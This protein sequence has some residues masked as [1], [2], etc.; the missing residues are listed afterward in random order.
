[1]R[2]LREPSWESFCIQ[3]FALCSEVSMS[4]SD[5]LFNDLQCAHTRLVIDLTVFGV[6]AEWR[7]QVRKHDERK[8][9]RQRMSD[10]N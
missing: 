2:L 6:Y 4:P 1:M 5:Y 8:L 7:E 10:A 9:Q 3:L